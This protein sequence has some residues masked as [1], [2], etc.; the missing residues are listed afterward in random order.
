[1]ARFLGFVGKTDHF[2]GLSSVSEPEWNREKTSTEWTLLMIFL[3]WRENGYT[4]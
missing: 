2:H 4:Q 1:M 3:T